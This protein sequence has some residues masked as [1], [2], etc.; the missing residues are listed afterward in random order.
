MKWKG[1]SAL[2]RIQMLL[3]ISPYESSLVSR[4]TEAAI[5]TSSKTHFL[6]K[7]HISV[8]SLKRVFIREH[9][10]C[11][12]ISS[13]PLKIAS[14]HPPALW[15]SEPSEAA[16]RCRSKA[17]ACGQMFLRT[18]GWGCPLDLHGYDRHSRPHRLQRAG[19]W[20]LMICGE[21]KEEWL[22][23]EL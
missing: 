6:T 2:Y 16:E 10:V 19:A 13:G 23:S 1:R 21:R 14:C 20:L 3:C 22:A 7:K 4:S 17:S 8:L 5:Q 18:G 15:G 9:K 11:T 12:S